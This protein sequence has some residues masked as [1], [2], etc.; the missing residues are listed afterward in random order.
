MGRRARGDSAGLGRQ[1][2]VE[3]YDCIKRV[4]DLDGV[5]FAELAAEQ[6]L[7]DLVLHLPLD[8]PPQRAGAVGWVVALVLGIDSRRGQP[9]R[10]ANGDTNL[11]SRI[12]CVAGLG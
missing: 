2:T 6:S 1:L 8:H 3:P 4:V 7:G 10:V 9:Q 12:V 11:A 5:A